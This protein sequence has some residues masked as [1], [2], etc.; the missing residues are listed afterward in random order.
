MVD[1]DGQFKYSSVVATGGNATD[2]TLQPV[3]PN[4]FKKQLRVI[5]TAPDEQ[6]IQVRLVTK[7]GAVV[8]QKEYRSR[9][10][11]NELRID[12][13]DQLVTGIYFLQLSSPNKVITEKLVKVD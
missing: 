9:K 10:G 7:M 11:L 3:Y 5:F 1:Q 4:P 6:T 12:E 2:L 8:Y 13:A